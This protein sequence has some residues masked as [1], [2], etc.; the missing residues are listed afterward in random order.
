MLSATG[1]LLVS[2]AIEST[3]AGLPLHRLALAVA[4]LVAL[5]TL[6]H[7]SRLGRLLEPFR[8]R[9]V[10][11]IPWGTLIVSW[12]L[13]VVYYG[14][15]GGLQTPND[16]VVLPFRAWSYF[17]PF[18]MLFAGFSHASISHLTG[19]LLGTLVFGTLAEYWWGHYTEGGRST[20]SLV[21]RLLATPAV[22]ATIVFPA[23]T[24]LVGLVGT[25]LAL[26]PVIGFSTVVFAFAGFA[27]VRYPLVVV[28]ASVGQGVVSRLLDAALVPTQVAVAESSFSTPWFA[29][30]AVQG[31]AIGL[32]V[33]VLAG[34]ALLSYRGESRPPASH[35]WAG[36]LLFAVSR[37][38]WAIYW[39]RGNDV[40]VLY[41]ALG[42]ALVFLLVA[43]VSYAVLARD[44]P[45]VPDQATANPTTMFERFDSITYR[46]FGLIVLLCG[47]LLVAAPAVP[48]NLTT[49]GDAELPGEPI[50]VEGYEI[51]Y[52]EDLPDGQLSA[53]PLE[54]FGESTQLNTSGVIVR[55]TDR[56]IWSTETSANRLADSGETTVRLG[57]PG[58]NETVT[59]HR[60]GWQTVGGASTYRVSLSHDNES[61]TPFASAPATAEPV[62]A[63]HRVSINA[64]TET[65]LVT[66]EPVEPEEADEADRPD[67]PDDTDEL[68]GQDE[69]TNETAPPAQNETNG[70][71]NDSAIVITEPPETADAEP[72][73]LP[74]ENESVT[75]GPLQL[76]NQNERLIAVEGST[77]VVVAQKE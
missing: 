67:E 70:G 25:L 44:E 64:T 69:Q 1:S 10:A 5:G 76:V 11:G 24:L 58:W 38:L 20:D 6:V 41:R 33:G 45:M 71:T 65:F 66:A 73:E 62:I 51:T 35:L 75:L 13:I 31:H 14:V 22:R 34:V 68:D 53:V 42:L 60:E 17:D 48:V 50:E 4:I 9:F 39:F 36:V 57:G 47:A 59:A 74:A 37:S 16:P 56:H 52:G 43:I 7:L 2:E 77:V 26:G 15:Q 54:A 63:G 23:I 46:Q 61:R 12:L 30:I 21:D 27:L 18:G 3:L 28:I 55:N 29:S 49:A 19:N 32:L 8:R 72:V 40:Y